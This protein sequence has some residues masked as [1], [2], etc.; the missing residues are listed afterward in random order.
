[1]F[2][3]CSSMHS[4][5]FDHFL[6]VREWEKLGYQTQKI[7]TYIYIC[8]C[9]CVR[10]CYAPLTVND[11]VRARSWSCR[12]GMPISHWCGGRLWPA[13]LYSMHQ[14]SLPL[15]HYRSLCFFVVYS[16]MSKSYNDNNISRV[17]Y[18]FSTMFHYCVSSTCA[19]CPLPVK[20]RSKMEKKRPDGKSSY[21]MWYC[22]LIRWPF[23]RLFHSLLTAYYHH[24]YHYHCYYS[25]LRKNAA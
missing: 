20:C 25:E 23:G 4:L 13:A 16:R 6:L 17:F 11:G 1:M 10:T 5:S 22:T 18:F 8:L 2:F 24:Y 12:Y 3:S 19:P 14:M 21:M 9:V 15:P 7:Y